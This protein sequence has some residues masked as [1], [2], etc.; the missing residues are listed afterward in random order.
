MI[1]F[2]PEQDHG[3]HKTEVIIP[4]GVLFTTFIHIRQ[5]NHRPPLRQ[6]RHCVNA[7]GTPYTRYSF[8]T[9]L[10]RLCKRAKTSRIYTPY[11]LRHTFASM[12]SDAG[13]ETTG[14]ARLMGHSTTRTLERYVVNTHEHHMKAVTAL[15]DLF[16]R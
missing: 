1:F 11:A 3:R 2:I 7:R 15:Q 5:I 16:C 14:L 8:K 12:E 13:T 4:E 9:K 10:A 6:L